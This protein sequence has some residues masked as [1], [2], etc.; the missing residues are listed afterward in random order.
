MSKTSECYSFN[1]TMV[2]LQLVIGHFYSPL[3]AHFQSHYGAIATVI[4]SLRCPRCGRTFNPTMV[5]LQHRFNYSRLNNCYSFQSHYGAIATSAGVNI[6]NISPTTFN[7]T[8]VRLQP[9]GLTV[10]FQS[11]SI[12][13]NPTMVRLQPFRCVATGNSGVAFNPTMVRLQ[14][15]LQLLLLPSCLQLSIPLWCDCNLDFPTACKQ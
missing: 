13:F 4:R 1:P 10:R 9:L 11:S 7:P 5:R 2:R 8:M 3:L 6:A 14:L 15:L 12:S